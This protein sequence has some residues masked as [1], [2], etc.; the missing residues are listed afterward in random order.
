MEVKTRKT[1]S[2]MAEHM[3]QYAESGMTQAAYCETHGISKATFGYWLKKQR[4]AQAT[5]TGSFLRVN[6]KASDY[7]HASRQVN[8]EIQFS[9]GVVIRFG[10]MVDPKYI[11]EL[12]R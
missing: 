8:I 12:I 10:S 3:A 11:K 4:D 5:S 7:N 9:N 6:S 2:A 1:P